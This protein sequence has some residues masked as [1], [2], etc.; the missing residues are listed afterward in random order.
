M[1]Y[2]S[3]IQVIPFSKKAYFLN[4]AIDAYL[5]VPVQNESFCL[6]FL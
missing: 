5:V 1:I 3:K 2:V 4:R 6:C